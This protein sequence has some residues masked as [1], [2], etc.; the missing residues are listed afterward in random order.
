M[1][2]VVYIRV[3]AIRSTLVHFCGSQMLPE[4]VSFEAKVQKIAKICDCFFDYCLR[5]SALLIDLWDGDRHEDY[6][7]NYIENQAEFLDDSLSFYPQNHLDFGMLEVDNSNTKVTFQGFTALSLYH[8]ARQLDGGD[9][10]TKILT[11][12]H[13]AARPIVRMVQEGIDTLHEFTIAAMRDSVSFSDF[14]DADKIYVPVQITIDAIT[15]T[16]TTSGAIPEATG[17]E[18]QNGDEIYF[19][20]EEEN[21][22]PLSVEVPADISLGTRYFA[23]N[24]SGSFPNLSF[25]IS[26]DQAGSNI[27]NFSSDYP[28]GSLN[29]VIAAE[30]NSNVNTTSPVTPSTDSSFFINRCVLHMA[31]VNNH[32][33]LTAADMRKLETYSASLKQ[34]SNFSPFMYD[35]EPVR[36]YAE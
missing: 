32:P 36:S 21:L 23:Q 12:A 7:D 20:D 31:Y 6:I 11:A 1:R 10:K 33:D 28:T 16:I 34:N 19:S 35:A 4:A 29:V 25:Q 26:T 2:C 24:V 18:W 15:N 9:T 30:T 14:H 13:Q 17:T 27:V 8:L 22:F 3:V 5:S